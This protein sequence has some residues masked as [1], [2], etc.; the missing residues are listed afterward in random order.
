MT[1]ALDFRSQTLRESFSFYVGGRDPERIRACAELADAVVVSGVSGPSTVRR[2]RDSGWDGLVLFDGVAYDKRESSLDPS[3][4]F[5]DQFSAGADRLLTPGQWVGSELG[6]LP[7]A[8]QIENEVMLAKSHGATCLLAVGRRWFTESALMDEMLLNLRELRSPIALVLGDTSDPMSYS[9][10]VDSLVAVSTRVDDLTIV[11]CDQAGIGALA[12]GATHASLGLITRHRHVVPP[13]VRSF[14][15]QNDRSA[16]VFVRDLLDWFTASRIG[17]WSTASI[18]PNCNAP[19]CDGQP[20]RRFLD[21]RFK[22]S[23]DLHNRTVLAALAEEVL[24]APAEDGVR[25]REFG[26]ICQEAVDRYG[27]MGSWWTDI[28]PKRQLTQWALFC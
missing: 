1:V 13:D 3:K 8:D 15:R 7:F 4:W 25:R 22:A 10:A 11:R 14:A 6:H 18:T 19:C 23:A 5:D 20:I 21:E 24:T 9:G 12:F 26:R 27:T 16:R 17:E 2:L 28:K